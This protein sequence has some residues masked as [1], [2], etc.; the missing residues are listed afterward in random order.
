MSA[1]G[2]SLAE[3]SVTPPDRVNLKDS[4][5]LFALPGV[6]GKKM[7]DEVGGENKGD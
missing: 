2:S 4:I 3:T 7:G 1:F 5:F 6:G